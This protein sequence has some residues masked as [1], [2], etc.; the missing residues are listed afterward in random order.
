MG[1]QSATGNRRRDVGQGLARVPSPLRVAI[2]LFEPFPQ[3][4][5]KA[6][7]ELEEKPTMAA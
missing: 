2:G 7:Q 1:R 4:L 5:V 6:R 3:S